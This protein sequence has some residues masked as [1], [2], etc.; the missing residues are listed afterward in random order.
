MKY[1]I[2]YFNVMSRLDI[3]R[4][5]R[6]YSGMGWSMDYFY[7]NDTNKWG[8]T[9]GTTR[10]GAAHASFTGKGIT[11]SNMHRAPTIINPKKMGDKVRAIRNKIKN[12]NR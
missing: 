4:R 8:D 3:M 6:E 10:A 7:A 2:P 11:G 9:D 12:N 5:I 1:G